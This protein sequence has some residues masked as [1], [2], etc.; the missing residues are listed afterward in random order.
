MYDLGIAERSPSRLR[1]SPRRVKRAKLDRH[2]DGEAA[3]PGQQGG[4][5]P[6]VMSDV[7]TQTILNVTPV[8]IPE[9]VPDTAVAKK[10][11]IDN[12]LV[13][14]RRKQ[15][16]SPSS[17]NGAGASRS[18][19]EKDASRKISPIGSESRDS[20]ADV[21]SLSEDEASHPKRS[22][23]GPKFHGK[24]QPRQTDKAKRKSEPTILIESVSDLELPAAAIGFEEDSQV[25]KDT[26]HKE[27][28][29]ETDRIKGKVS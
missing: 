18:L 7:D 2:S 6:S 16:G 20:D 28:D 21:E 26:K 12:F 23:Q 4:D 11:P 14:R 15:R 3:A 22:D 10:G 5:G 27:N 19:H 13:P 24:K 29:K 9:T 25:S 17:K 1:S 8:D